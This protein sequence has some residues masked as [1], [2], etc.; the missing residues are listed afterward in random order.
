MK[1]KP[2]QDRVL[3]KREDAEEKTAGGIIIP[4]TSKEKPS[5][6]IVVA[7]GPGARNDRGEPIPMTLEVGDRVFF[8]KWGGTELKVDN[9]ELLVMKESDILATIE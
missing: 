6:G 1:I 8:T 9:D 7:V 3:V 4:D 5:K 2:L